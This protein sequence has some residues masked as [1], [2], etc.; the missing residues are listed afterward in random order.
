MAVEKLKIKSKE[1]IEKLDTVKDKIKGIDKKST[2]IADLV[3]RIEVL[4]EHL[5]LNSD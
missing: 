4:E 2:K 1:E 3:K 5:G